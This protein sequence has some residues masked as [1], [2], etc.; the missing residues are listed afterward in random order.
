MARGTEAQ[1]SRPELTEAE[2]F[3]A[4]WVEL[5]GRWPETIARARELPPAAVHERVKGEW[6]FV[7]TLRHLLFVTDAWVSR[8]VLGDSA[9]YHPLGLPPT[10]MKNPAVPN[11]LEAQPSL[12]E[13]LA[14]RE[15]RVAVARDV[16]A[17]LTD[18]AL[19][20][21]TLRVRGPGYPRA[22]T[23]PLRRC[24]TVLVSEE[25]QHRLYAERDLA[26]LLTRG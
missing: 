2:D 20:D 4:A 19:A 22:G 21:S 10:G 14:L 13:V 11:D 6:S 17:D 24:V 15:G 9:P 26:V 1:G 25:W 8:A 7:Q 12:D 16:L 3:R 23:Y 18:D 5:E